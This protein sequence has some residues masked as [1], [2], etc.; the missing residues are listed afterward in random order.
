MIRRKIF[1]LLAFAGCWGIVTGQQPWTFSDPKFS[2][3]DWD[4]YSTS[5]Q[6]DG[7]PAQPFLVTAIPYNGNYENF[8]NFVPGLDQP[9]DSSF[10]YSNGN[11]L[12]SMRC[13]YTFDSAAVY[14]LVP[15][16]NQDNTN[17][18]EYHVVADG[19]TELVRWT[20]VD[21][22]ADPDF[23]L[24]DFKRGIGFLGGVRADWNHWIAV[25]L[26]YKGSNTI[27]SS[28]I[29]FW[30]KTKPTIENIFIGSQLN[31][32]LKKVKSPEFS[33]SA[34]SSGLLAGTSSDEMSGKLRFKAGEENII[35][36]LAGNIYRKQAIE[37]QLIRNNRIVIPWKPNDFDNNFIWLKKLKGGHYT[38]KVRYSAQRENVTSFQFTV[39]LHWYEQAWPKWVLAALLI[40]VSFFIY[41][42]IAQHRRASLEQRRRERLRL[43]LQVVRSQLNPHFVFNAL[44]SI[45]GLI[46]HGDSEQASHYLTEFSSLLRETLQNRNEEFMPLVK[47]LQML[48]T[49]LQ[50]E[51]LRFHFKYE[52]HVSGAIDTAATEVPALL[53]QP[54]VENAIRHGAAPLYEKG[55]VRI[56]F[57]GVN[58]DLRISISDNGKG[59][60]TNQP[61]NGVGLQLVKERIAL[62]N[63]TF[64]GRTISLEFNR[65][66]DVETIVVLLF[67]NW[68]QDAD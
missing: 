3:I 24:N 54:L 35:F 19:T 33:T 9:V 15:N 20:E 12:L 45:Q 46:N 26:R 61:N 56:L 43:E 42:Y 62:L 65:I 2:S 27:L 64:T 51:Q 58:N 4:N 36:Y 41:K 8:E 25:Q 48:E 60:G 68:L 16:I 21:R 50:L 23:Q 34:D 31:S 57:S 55:R 59:F 28:A 40:S 39:G 52:V 5:F 13:L 67:E 1:A 17:E 14:F 7:P 53:I 22:F 47:E 37:Y 30:K 63:Q 49:Y 66:D 44:T 6:Q 18:Y 38:L 32:F 10:G 29:V 11:F